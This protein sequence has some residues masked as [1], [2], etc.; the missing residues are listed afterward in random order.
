[1]KEVGQGGQGLNV[2]VLVY[3]GDQIYQAVK[4]RGLLR[5]TAKVKRDTFRRFFVAVLFISDCV[6]FS[7]LCWH[8]PPSLTYP[9]L[10][11]LVC[12][13]IFF[14]F[15]FLFYQRWQCFFFRFCQL[16][17]EV[18]LSVNVGACVFFFGNFRFGCAAESFG[19]SHRS[20]RSSISYDSSPAVVRGGAGSVLYRSNPGSL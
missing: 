15:C 9:S 19:T 18:L 20:D 1:M 6:S 2:L 11:V 16:H 7:V 17:A 13:C 14:C 3:E 4:P 12:T 5:L 10:R 8:L